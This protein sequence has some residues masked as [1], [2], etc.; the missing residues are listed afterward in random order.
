MTPIEKWLLAATRG[1]AEESAAQVRAE[2]LEHYQSAYE[3]SLASGLPGSEA[4]LATVAALG[5]A[6]AANRQ[7][8]RVLLTSRD[9]KLLHYMTLDRSTLPPGRVRAGK[10]LVGILVA[11]AIAGQILGAWKDHA[12]WYLNAV[13]ALRFVSWWLPV[14]TL[15]R[16]RIFRR[17]RWIVLIAG[18][19]LTAWYG[20]PW[21]PLAVLIVEGYS[22][23]RRM[24]VRRKLAVSDWP[25]QLYR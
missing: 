16:G 21:P 11:E 1:L 25:K 22:D 6:K 8:R 2:I 3:E 9:A 23:Y 13:F 24:T 10:W 12:L 18:A 17:A 5:D 19:A 7:Y 14:N 4:E 15:Q 20:M